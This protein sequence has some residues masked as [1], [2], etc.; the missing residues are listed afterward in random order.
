MDR[1][2]R[3]FRD[4]LIAA[5]PVA[6]DHRE[7]Y[8]RAVQEMLHKR[9]SGGHKV[10]LVVTTIVAVGLAAVFG[11]MAVTGAELPV[12]ARAAF[13]VGVVFAVGWVVLN[14]SILKRGD[15]NL[16]TDANVMTGMTWAFVVILMTFLLL[17]AG[18]MADS[19][20]AVHMLVAGLV[21]LVM[22]VAFLITN[23]VDQAELNTREKLLKIEHRLAQL[24]ERLPGD[25]AP[26]AER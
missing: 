5:D 24:A 22:G 1:E 6:S 20:R 9:L 3:Q 19:A 11:V 2:R 26:E 23:R 16:R 25:V 8:E 15:I 18:S 13:G 7:R 12:L 14:V 21:F 4:E 10:M 17:L